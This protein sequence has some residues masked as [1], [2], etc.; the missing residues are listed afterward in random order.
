MSKRRYVETGDVVHQ[1][2]GT[3]EPT[4][5]DNLMREVEAI[6]AVEPFT[7]DK[8]MLLVNTLNTKYGACIPLSRVGKVTTAND[9]GLLWRQF[10]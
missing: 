6:S 2:G 7:Q 5:V 4:M 10:G 1:S 9:L 3:L 8:A